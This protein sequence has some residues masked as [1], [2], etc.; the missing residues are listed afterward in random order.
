MLFAS[1][2][3]LNRGYCVENI[4]LKA[5]ETYN[6]NL[7]FLEDIDP[8]LCEKI[9]ALAYAIEQGYYQEKYSLEYKDEYF[10]VLEPATGNWLYGANSKTHAEMAAKSINYSKTENV[11]ETFADVNIDDVY[12]KELEEMDISQSSYSGAAGLINYSNK[13]AD[14]EKTSMKKLYKFIFI[15]VGLGLHLTT[16]HE[17]LNSNIYF[18]V[19]DDLE[20]FRLSLFVTDYQALTQNGAM[21]IF[22]IFDEE[23]AFRNATNLFLKEHFIYNHYIKFFYLLS[24]KEK[25]LRAIQNIIVG[26]NYLTFNYSALSNSLLRPLVHLK[27]GYKL[28]DISASY[29]DSIFTDKPFLLLGAGPS[30]GKNIKWL[31]ENHHK[32]IIVA[33]TPLLAKLEELNIRPD[34]ITHVHG[35]ADALPHVQ[36]VKNISFF[37]KTICIFGGFTSPDFIKYFKKEN[38]FVFE[39]SSRY[40]RW[41]TGLTSS[42]IGS[43]SYGLL[44]MLQTK[45]IYLLGLDFAPDQESGSTHSLTHNYVRN[46]ELQEDET[47]GGGLVFN[48][49]IVKTKGNFRDEVFTTLMFNDWKEECNAVAR[50]YKTEKNEHVYNL[51]DGAYIDETIVLKPDETQITSLALLDKES[52]NSE[53][54]SILNSKAENFLNPVELHN[55]RLRIKYCD[56]IIDILNRHANSNHQNINQY[57][58]N[59]LGVFYNI[60]TDEGQVESSDINRAITLYLQFVSGFIFD[61]INTKEI[62]NEEILIKHLDKVIIPQIIRV[63]VYFKVNLK[64]YLSFVAEK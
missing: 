62:V 45:E 1:T 64:D 8:R 57:H 35:F 37:D 12:A 17:K 60:L 58:Y 22:S 41:D 34:I 54:L 30:F 24:H 52:A 2:E 63:I 43:I 6:K 40:K 10:D 44:L 31:C 59:L 16:I 47:I 38:V 46:I 20:L 11:Y 19:E 26:Q 14:K 36:K 3:Q 50:S 15:G 53:L 39:G 23:D 33:V 5:I 7:L 42:N 48:S 27:N 61:L 29:K 13:H 4:E 21:L 51:S 56:N 25:K 18:I 9:Y 49:A 28:L 55:I 32:F